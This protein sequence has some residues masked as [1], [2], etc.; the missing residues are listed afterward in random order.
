[1]PAAAMLLPLLAGAC[2]KAAADPNDR[3]VPWTYGPT[4]G[5]ASAEH[6]HGTG[7][8]GRAPVAKGWHCRLRDGKRLTVQPYELASSHPLFGK[9]VLA[10]GLFD[11]TGKE[12]DTRVTDVVTADRATF[13]F[14]LDAD[15]AAR[16]WDVVIWYRSS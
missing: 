16:L 4:T 14:E 1:M 8:K 2:G 6:V 15:V 10:I 7:G 9:V 13:A 3:E 12:L 11:R 5:G